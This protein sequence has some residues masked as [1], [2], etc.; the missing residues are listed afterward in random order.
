INI[1][2]QQSDSQDILRKMTVLAQDN[3]TDLKSNY[4]YSYRTSRKYEWDKNVKTVSGGKYGL[5]S[6]FF[7]HGPDGDSQSVFEGYAGIGVN[8]VR[9]FGEWWTGVKTNTKTQGERNAINIVEQ[10]ALF[11][12]ALT[13]LN[14]VDK[15]VCG[16]KM[17][18][19]LKFAIMAYVAIKLLE[20]SGKTGQYMVDRARQDSSI[21]QGL[22]GS[23][24][25][26]I[27]N[28]FNN[29]NQN[30]SAAGTGTSTGIEVGILNHNKDPVKHTL[31]TGDGHIYQKHNGCM[32]NQCCGNN[33]LNFKGQPLS[34]SQKMIQAIKNTV[35]TDI[36]QTVDNDRLS[37]TGSHLANGLKGTLNVTKI[38]GIDLGE[39]SFTVS[40]NVP[41]KYIKDLVP[42]ASTN[43]LQQAAGT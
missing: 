27:P 5:G 28:N 32:I 18:G 1:H 13:V 26:N 39:K 6:Q 10:G 42:E 35:D 43:P 3:E 2:K 8:S 38:N 14:L 33:V 29:A 16:N 19:F 24:S 15:Y 22:A 30:N 36:K 12:G 7:G 21:V 34:I 37:G 17:N 23:A 41:E 20:R 4:A 31:Y 25:S 11:I 9:G 40:Y